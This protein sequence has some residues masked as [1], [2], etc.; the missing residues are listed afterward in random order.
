M[1]PVRIL[2]LGGDTKYLPL[3]RS[4]LQALASR[5]GENGYAS[6]KLIIEGT[7]ILI[8][9]KEDVHRVT[10]LGGSVFMDSGS[11]DIQTVGVLDPTIGDT[12]G[13]INYNAAIK[14]QAMDKKLLGPID[15]ISLACVPPLDASVAKSFRV[16]VDEN[17]ERDSVQSGR[18]A[19]KKICTKFAP[20]SIFTGKMRLFFQ[21]KYGRELADWD[22]SINLA[23]QP[24]SLDTA[25]KGKSFQFHP[26]LCGI[27]TD[28]RTNHWLVQINLDGDQAMQGLTIF[29]MRTTAQV[30]VMRAY[31]R[32]TSRSAQERERIEAYIL[33]YSEPDPTDKISIPLDIPTG[34]AMGYGWHFSWSGS[35]ID[36]VQQLAQ[37]FGG[38]NEAYLA[39]HRR[40]LLNR[41]EGDAINEAARWSASIS[42]MESQLWGNFKWQTVIAYPEW[43]SQELSIF[44][45]TFGMRAGTNA[46]VY[47][48]WRREGFAEVFEMVRYSYTVPIVGNRWKIDSTP[49]YFNGT[50]AEQAGATGVTGCTYSSMTVG[51]EEA[52]TETFSYPETETSTSF[53]TTSG[54]VSASARSYS[55]SRYYSGPKYAPPSGASS[56]PSDGFI[57]AKP[58]YSGMTP[59]VADL[60]DGTT[61]SCP[62]GVARAHG[63]I[64]GYAPFGGIFEEFGSL[65]QWTE[66]STSHVIN[67]TFQ[68]LL[69]IPFGDAEAVYMWG[70]KYHREHRTNVSSRRCGTA[71]LTSR[72]VTYNVVTEIGGSG[73]VFEWIGY[74][75]IYNVDYRSEAPTTDGSIYITPDEALWSSVGSFCICNAGTD[76]KVQA[77]IVPSSQFFAGD[78]ISS[79]GR[80]FYT[81]TSV[82]GDIKGEGIDITG[83]YS[84]AIDTAPFVFVGWA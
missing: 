62:F 58:I 25:V 56:G 55:S 49:P 7:T 84:V 11:V 37:P 17:G 28:S 35:S 26:A 74:Q 73:A 81:R 41:R 68:T 43:G 64:T 31:L 80:Q 61:N 38:E 1:V 15:V 76:G 10:L 67:E 20:P 14:Q 2:L 12:D 4:K 50:V 66:Y 19:V 51:L 23:N 47:C 13:T 75:G 65:P 82:G 63:S 32:D 36:I 6:E 83:G 24:A 42:L 33:A 16:P 69:V 59:P 21:A 54:T 30:Q 5:V 46:P 18:L 29:R 44:G 48:F 71:L 39:E 52:V 8:D 3:A 27:Y 57:P 40:I 34:S 78:P 45:S 9:V 22:Y 72:C 60:V 77:N 79:V 53:S 70:Q